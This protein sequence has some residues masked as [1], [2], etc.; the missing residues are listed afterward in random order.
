MGTLNL[1]LLANL[2][3]LGKL[4]LN[5]A[6]WLHNKGYIIV[7]NDGIV[8]KIEKEKEYY[9][10]TINGIAFEMGFDLAKGD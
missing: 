5:D 3:N 1:D 10:V 7:C 6:E 2:F 8:S 9:S 4:T